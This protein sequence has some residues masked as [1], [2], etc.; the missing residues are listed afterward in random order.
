[1][2]W[3]DIHDPNGEYDFAM[4]W[5]YVSSQYTPEDIQAMINEKGVEEMQHTV[6]E[7]FK[8]IGRERALRRD[9]VGSRK[10]VVQW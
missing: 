3:T 9:W 7:H 10:T 6:N 8:F 4:E 1:M 5:T 2:E